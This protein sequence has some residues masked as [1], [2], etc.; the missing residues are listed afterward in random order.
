LILDGDDAALNSAMQAEAVGRTLARATDD[1]AVAVKAML[2]AIA[3]RYDE[4]LAAA[5]QSLNSQVLAQTIRMNSLVPAAK[6]LAAL[7]RYEAALDVVEKDF[8]PMIDAQ[9]TRLMGI[10]LVAL[11]LILH[12]LQRHERINELAG[13]AFAYARDSRVV[14]VE[15]RTNLANI[16]G[17]DKAFAALP[18]PNPTD[19]TTDRVATLIDGLITELRHRIAHSAP[20]PLAEAPTKAV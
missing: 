5:M 6:S 2:L 1:S 3:D 14:E 4:A 19:L 11:V 12:Q 9:R 16:V 10:Q 18:T 15:V 17:D 7:G 8:G 20:R 13:F